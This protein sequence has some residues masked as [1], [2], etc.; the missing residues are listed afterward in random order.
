MKHR[1][2]TVAYLAVCF[3]T[4]GA[5]SG[6]SQNVTTGTLTGVVKDM[7]GGV[8]PGATVTALHG[9]TGTSYEAVTEGDGTFHLLN[10]RVGGPY[11][12]TVALPGFKT[13]T[14]PG[15]IAKLGE[16]TNIP[17]QLQLDTVNETV[18][19]RGDA[20]DA[21]FTPS[22]AGAAANIPP[23][24]IQSLPTISRS[25]FDLARTS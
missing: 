5:W 2:R 9:P 22:H 15:I 20:A 16:A 3:L 24:A 14:Q 23:E 18:E 7:Q 25:L 10:V 19:V 17:V 13:F 11:T 6:F 8:V 1:S 4:F 21:I 12:V